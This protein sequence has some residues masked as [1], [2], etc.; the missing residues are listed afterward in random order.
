MKGASVV[1]AAGVC[2]GLDGVGHVIP[3]YCVPP[4][5]KMNAVRYQDVLHLVSK[6]VVVIVMCCSL[7]LMLVMSAESFFFFHCSLAFTNSSARG[8]VGSHA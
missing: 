7:M 6:E 2:I 3:P 8:N 5:A 1:A 4:E